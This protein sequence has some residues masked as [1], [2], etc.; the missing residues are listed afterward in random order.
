MAPPAPLRFVSS[1]SY[2]RRET[3]HPRIC[4]TLKDYHR[5]EVPDRGDAIVYHNRGES[6]YSYIQR[7][8]CSEM[9]TQD[10]VDASISSATIIAFVLDPLKVIT[11]EE[12]RST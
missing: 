3:G 9:A 2:P 11:D 1:P 10:R 7:S 5:I 8:V 12:W 6:S 4:Q